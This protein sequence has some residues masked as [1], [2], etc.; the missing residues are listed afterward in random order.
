M[1]DPVRPLRE[2]VRLLSSLLGQVVRRHAGEAVF[3]A[4]EELRIACRDRRA[5]TADGPSL[6]EVVAR[7]DALPLE[8]AAP[9]ARAFTLFFVLSN[10]AEHVHL[11][12]GFRTA[13]GPS[14]APATIAGTL[15]DLKAA[16]VDAGQ[17]RSV[18]ERLEVRPVLTAHPTE[19]TRRTVLDLQGRVANLLLRRDTADEEER[20]ALEERLDAEVEILWLTAEVR[21]DR[22]SVLDEVSTA[23]WYLEDRLLPVLPGVHHTIARACREVYG[24]D[25]GDRALICLGSWVGGDR[26]GNPF[27]TPDT[28][29]SAV[30]RMAHAVLSCFLDRVQEL[31]RCL[32]VSSRIAR[33]APILRDSIENDREALPEVYARN[34]RRDADEPVR[35]KLS[36]IAARL[37]AT[38]RLI[39]ARDA[40]NPGHEP[41][42][43]PDPASW[44][45]D[46][47]LVREA[48]EV[49]GAH[50]AVAVYLAPLITLARTVGFA[51]YR[52][53]VR[54]D[55]AVFAEAVSEVARSVGLDGLEGDA[56]KAELLARRPLLSPFVRYTERTERTIQ[57][58]RAVRELGREVGPEAVGTCVVSMCR[59][60][61]DVL[62]VLLLAR[63]AGLVDLSRDPPRSDLD[64]VPLF[65]TL[66][67]IQAAPAIL[68]E[69]LEV[70]AYERQLR[71]RSRCQTIMLGYSDSAKDA[72]LLAAAWALYRA[73]EDLADL[74]RSARV[75]LTLFH[76]RG[77][78][79]GRGGGSPAYRA[80]CALPPG[81]VGPR[82]RITEQGEVVSHKYG[83]RPVAERSLEI[84]IAGTLRAAMSDW[85]T[86]VDQATVARFRSAMEELAARSLSVYRT[87]VF[88]SDTLFRMFR[89]CTPVQELARVHFGSRPAYREHREDTMAGIR[90]IP[91]VF[92]WTQVRLLLPGWLGVGTALNA[93]ADQPGGL[94]LLRDMADR[95]PFF[96]D[97]L[98]KV[99]MVCAKADP[100]IA[101]LYIQR[102]GGDEALFATLEEEWRRTVT[103]LLAIR[104]ADRL[105]SRDPALATA[106]ALRNPY[107]DV[108]SLLQ[109]SLMSR[110]RALETAPVPPALDAALGSTINGLAQGLRN[111]G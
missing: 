39:A 72:G 94:D 107:L 62:R 56:L 16:G 111:T 2:D 91:W 23:R 110:K 89:H 8:I 80:L 104:R 83:L 41:A 109:V 40:G 6:D 33:A 59:S 68:R 101:R 44:I 102:L 53:D 48:L 51:G 87:H 49:A 17:V 50:K 13:D 60:P 61:D 76:G 90:A 4:V 54:E 20:V 95:W 47:E 85:R 3:Q 92:G 26:D 42:A 31:V 46:L 27:V 24:L 73:Q 10:T 97:F 69:L 57:M 52:L 77:G 93:V 1:S 88:G 96:D 12:R 14:G 82:I 28:T 86:G 66:Q 65:E 21:A 19:S 79:V 105:L 43:Y 58:F 36:L 64:V 38:R 32:S 18:L 67:D 74:C 37:E 30:R 25:I 35:M 11:V 70:P 108:L 34:R 22:L 103:L 106:I 98:S 7:V 84:L 63:E 71:A 99:E 78:T 15:R 5:G 45:A 100:E 29:R 75:D 9:V 55:A 81:T